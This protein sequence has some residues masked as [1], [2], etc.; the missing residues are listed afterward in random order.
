MFSRIL[1]ATQQFIKYITNNLISLAAFVTNQFRTFHHKF[2][3]T[4]EL[5]ISYMKL[6]KRTKTLELNLAIEFGRTV[7]STAENYGTIQVIHAR[8]DE[9]KIIPSCLVILS[10]LKNQTFTGF[11]Y[12]GFYEVLDHRKKIKFRFSCIILG[13]KTGKTRCFVRC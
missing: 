5:S 4:L 2:S 1:P 13:L 9:T 6:F 10:R 11:C 8:R 3:N 12:T 7:W